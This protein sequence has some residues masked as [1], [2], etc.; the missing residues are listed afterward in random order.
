MGKKIAYL[1]PKGTFCEEA[2][3]KYIQGEQA[4]LLPCNSIAAVFSSVCN[5]EA[6]TGIVP[7]ENSSE[8]AV[9]QTLD[10]LAYEYDLKIS[11]EIILDVKHNLLTKPNQDIKEISYVFSHPQALAQCQGYLAKHL[12]NA[13]II[14]TSSTAEAVQ[15][16]A[17]SDHSW[18]AVGT[19]KAARAYRL[20]V[21]GDNIND[22]PDN[23][24]RFIVLSREESTCTIGCKTSLLVSVLNQPGALFQVLKEFTLRGINLTKIESRP[25]KMK[26]G[27]YL[28]YID[29]EGHRSEANVKEALEGLKTT[30]QTVKVLGSYPSAHKISKKEDEYC[31]STI[32]DLR[33]EIDLID[34]QIINLLGRRTR[35]VKKVSNFKRTV[36]MVRDLDRE[37]FIINKLN[38]L[39]T[40][41]GVSPAVVTKIYRILLD[42]SVSVQQEKIGAKSKG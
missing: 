8:G 22:Q 2:V 33:H 10:L 34:D 31:S 27:D 40:T 28:F 20:N 30:A 38:N 14:S 32:N 16:V 18:A 4:E 7:I 25:T 41:R 21:A 26:F 37:R 1:G 11:G 9:N 15:Q 42:Y 39:A 19:T 12:P 17:N 13:Q 6:D 24:T 5:S 36:S 23:Q 3:N 29:L 35:L